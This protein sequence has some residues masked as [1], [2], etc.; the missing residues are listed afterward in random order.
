MNKLL[1]LAIG[2]GIGYGASKYWNTPAAPPPPPPTPPTNTKTTGTGTTT[3]TSTLPTVAITTMPLTGAMVK[4]DPLTQV[5]MGAYRRGRI[6]Y[7]LQCECANGKKCT[8]DGTCSCCGGSVVLNAV[9][10]YNKFN[11]NKAQVNF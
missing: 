10:P 11:Y 3:N 5:A 1:F 8:G 6:G 2:V 4:T 9:K 7:V